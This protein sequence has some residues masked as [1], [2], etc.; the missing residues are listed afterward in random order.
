MLSILFSYL[1]NCI[2][3]FKFIY[4]AK[5][6]F[7]PIVKVTEE[8]H[9]AHYK[10]ELDIKVISHEINYLIII[11]ISMPRSTM[12]DEVCMKKKQNI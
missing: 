4:S 12:W 10:E 5:T 11:V 2:M 8:N 1:L 3:I 7:E 6:Y 9:M